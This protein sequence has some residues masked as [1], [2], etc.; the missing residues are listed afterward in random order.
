MQ[1]PDSQ[2]RARARFL[3]HHVWV[4]PYRPDERYPAGEYPNQSPGGDGL[5]RWTAADRGLVDEDV[6]LWYVFGSHHFPRLE[7]WPVMPVVRC[8]FQLRPVG[9]FDRNPA[10]DVPPPRGHACHPARRD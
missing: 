3:D 9:F 6:V 2:V 4:T 10:L 1:Q 7:D 5:E 8:G